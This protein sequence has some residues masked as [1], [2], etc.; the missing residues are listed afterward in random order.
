M[1]IFSSFTFAEDIFDDSDY[2]D[3]DFDFSIQQKSTLADFPMQEIGQDELSNTAIAG[4]LTTQAALKSKKPTNEENEEKRLKQ[5]ADK[6][7]DLSEI[8]DTLKYSQIQIS[9]PQ[10]EAPIYNTPNGRTYTEHNTHTVER[11]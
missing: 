9:A 8:S 4:A 5:K 11:F 10:F 6:E 1:L 2:D 3:I 7:N